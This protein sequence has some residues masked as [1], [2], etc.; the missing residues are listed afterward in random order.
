MD[1]ERITKSALLARSGW[2]AT[3]VER[4]LGDPDER[5]KVFGRT[6]PLAL[7]SVARIE[8]AEASDAFAL[9]QASVAKR[10][11]AA[12]KAVATKTAKLMAAIEMMPVSVRRLGLADAKRQAIESY[13]RRAC[14][15]VFASPSDEPAFLERI[16]VNFIRHELTEYDAALW[17]FAGKTGIVLA[18]AEIRSRVYSAIAQA[19]PALGAECERQIQA[20]Q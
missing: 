15:D 8:Q 18:V 17:E 11:A 13:N 1:S 7:Y 4:L 20:R 9:A 12:A 19:Y 3:L 5:K 14:G 2:T 6:V 16:T 10:K